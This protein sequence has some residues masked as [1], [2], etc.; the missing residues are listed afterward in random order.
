MFCTT[1]R[2]CEYP[3]EEHSRSGAG[4]YVLQLFWERH[5]ELKKSSNL[6]HENVDYFTDGH[7]KDSRAYACVRDD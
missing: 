4:P 6:E 2:V 7:T 1:L 3:F 5:L